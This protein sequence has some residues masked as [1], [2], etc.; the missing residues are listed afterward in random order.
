M[1]SL[2]EMEI[3]VMNTG[4]VGGT[5]DDERSKKVR[6]PHSSA[7]VEGIVSNSIEWELDPDFGYEIATSVPGIDDV[8]LLQPKRLYERQDRSGEY[9][10]IVQRLKGE[11]REYLDSFTGLA[12]EIGSAI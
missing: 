9:A 12:D 8:E 6:I 3:F 10:E 11:R 4:R 2:P 7:V 5:D 1:D